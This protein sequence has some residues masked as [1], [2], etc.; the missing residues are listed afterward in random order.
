[1]RPNRTGFL[2]IL[3]AVGALVLGLPAQAGVRTPLAGHGDFDF[4]ADV[5]VFPTPDGGA[6][7][8]LTL[9]LDH[10]Q[11][12]FRPAHGEPFLAEVEVHLKAAQRGVVAVDTT[13]VYEF[14]A[15]SLEE[16]TDPRRFR[17]VEIPFAIDPGTWAVTLTVADRQAAADEPFRSRIESSAAGVLV[18]PKW[19]ESRRFS[20][21]EF[22]LR[23]GGDSLPNPE[24]VFGVVQDTLE[25]Y[26][27]VMGAVPGKTET[28]TFEIADPTYGGVER[29]QVR[30]V[31]ESPH[32]ARMYRLP[33]GTFPEGT[34]VLRMIPRGEEEDGVLEAE[35]LVAWKMGRPGPSPPV[36]FSW[37]PSSSSMAISSSVST[38]S[39]RPPSP[40]C[41]SSSGSPGIPRRVRVKTRPTRPFRSAWPTPGASSARP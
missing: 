14:T 8:D 28:I 26:F 2:S 32:H 12:R 6:R 30:F 31:P 1:M 29:Q 20:D 37:R 35:F 13:Q 9:R 23:S 10:S 22:R 33:V 7:V 39:A 24:R 18:V 11:I 36:I 27:E 40:R 21:P 16:A 34:Y 41:S 4:V 38:V 5:P 15:E 25:V 3:V 17:L 19:G